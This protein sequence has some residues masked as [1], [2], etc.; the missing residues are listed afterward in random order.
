MQTNHP[1]WE[2]TFEFGL[3]NFSN[4]T[5]LL[6][7]CGLGVMAD[8]ISPEQLGDW[9]P[10]ERGSAVTSPSKADEAGWTSFLT[11]IEQA[12]FGSAFKST[13][14]YYDGFDDVLPLQ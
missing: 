1:A 14:L 3:C 2:E 8:E 7:K 11:Y 4:F 9:F 13:A 5:S 6:E 10:P 12:G